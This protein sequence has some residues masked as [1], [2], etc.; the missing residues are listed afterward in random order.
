MGLINISN[1]K[2][3][4]GEQLLFE[5][6]TIEIGEK[7][8]IGLTGVNGT[9]KTTLF[10]MITGE[11][12]PDEGTIT[13]G[14]YTTLGYMEQH[15]QNDLNKT[16]YEEVLTVFSGLIETEEEIKAVNEA[17]NQKGLTEDELKKLVLR[18]HSLNERFK[19]EGGLTYKSIARST[20]IGLGFTEPE[21]GQP[22][23]TLSGGQKSKLSLGKMLLSN[24]NILLLDEPTN[25]LDIPS[26]EWLETFLLGYNGAFIVISHDRYFLDKVT[27]KTVEIENNKVTVC[28]GNYSE[29]LKVKE[30]NKDILEH[31]YKSQQKEIT[32]IEGIIE[33]QRRWGREKNIKT[34]ESKQKVVDKLK[35]SLV[36][37]EKDVSKINFTFK[38]RPGG[39]NDVLIVKDLKKRFEGKPLFENVNMHIKKGERVFL[40]GENGSGK[41]TLFKILL[42]QLE[43]D[44]GSY[45]IGTNIFVGHYSQTQEDLSLEKN[46]LEEVTNVFPHMSQTTIRTALA[47]FQFKG[48]DVFKT[49]STLSGGERARV[50][51]L[52]LILSDV[53][54]LLLDEPTNHL[55]I[56][57]RQALEDAFSE[58][59]G[60]LLI[61]SHDRFFINKMADKIY[62]LTNDGVEEYS[63][64]Y[65]YFLQQRK[66][67]QI[68]ESDN[69]Q[70][71]SPQK[72]DYFL[73]K[74]LAAKQRRLAGQISRLQKGIEE[75]EEVLANLQALQLTEEYTTDYV[76]A[77]EIATKIETQEK[78][79]DNLYKNWGELQEEQDSLNDD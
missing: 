78:I 13:M 52:K 45:K 57:S 5:N 70:D 33:Q 71:D 24:A 56:N 62:F 48:D 60:T 46:I 37:P 79:I 76:K 2:K 7:D 54:L 3:S 68:N 14:K 43:S 40:L 64:N 20:L 63:G 6:L 28:N 47:S 21:L 75:N 77:M 9:G 1:L 26:V 61:I 29:Y 17:I 12:L 59:D 8:R 30:K 15:V 18:Q 58:Y 49:I 35:A 4:F 73:K 42:D 38:S 23:K 41:T 36:T 25:H 44:S 11:I 72:N 27:T 74:E 34:A 66:E 53:N 16:V 55:D 32:R 50:S 22:V 31:Q 39:G 51:L 65:D 67:I 69:Q 10:K 19:D